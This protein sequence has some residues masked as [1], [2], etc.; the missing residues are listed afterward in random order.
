M[1]DQLVYHY[2]SLETFHKIISNSSC[3]FIELRAT[4]IDYLNDKLEH[5]IAVQ[6][7][8]DKLIEYD[9]EQNPK[10]YLENLLTEKT[11]HFS[12]MMT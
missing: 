7:L 10:K 1:N 8:K 6:L 4:H 2:T 11:H 5:K 9:N 3:E 12:N